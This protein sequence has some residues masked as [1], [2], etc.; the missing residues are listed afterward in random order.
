MQH[1]AAL[2]RLKTSNVC[3]TQ[4][5]RGKESRTCPDLWRTLSPENIVI[6]SRFSFNI[7]QM[8]RWIKSLHRSVLSNRLTDFFIKRLTLKNAKKKYF[9]CGLFYELPIFFLTHLC[10]SF[11]CFY[12]LIIVIFFLVVSVTLLCILLYFL[13]FYVLHLKMKIR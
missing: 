6:D 4:I 11:Y 3:L 1:N 5:L 2:C 9:Q 10:F 7:R 8:F 13:Q 12:Y